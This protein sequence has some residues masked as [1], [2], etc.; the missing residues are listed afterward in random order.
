MTYFL[1]DKPIERVASGRTGGLPSEWDAFAARWQASNIEGGYRN[2]EDVKGRREV[3]TERFDTAI[4]TLGDQRVIEGLAERGLVSP[5]MKTLNR[6]LYRNSP[7]VVQAIEEMARADAADNPD[8]WG[9]FDTSDDAVEKEA[10][11]RTA[12]EY[13]ELQQT[14]AMSPEGAIRDLA[15]E[16]GSGMLNQKSIP[17]LVMGGGSGSFLRVAGTEALINMGVEATLLPSQ[18]QVAEDLQIADPNVLEQLGTA[19]VAGAAFGVGAEALGRGLRYVLGRRETRPAGM[20]PLEA[21]MLTQRLE[22]AISGPRADERIGEVLADAMP[23]RP[24]PP[25]GMPPLV[26]RED[27]QVIQLQ[28]NEPPFGRGITTEVLPPSGE[29]VRGVMDDKS[30]TALAQSAL[31]EA[32]RIERA[33]TGGKRSPLMQAMKR[34]GIKINP[35]TP[36]GQELTQILGGRAEANRTVPGFFSRKPR[37]ENE[38]NYLDNMVASEWE[39][40][41]PGISAA[42]GVENGYL[43]R[44]GVYD[45]I[46]REAAKDFSWM[47]GVQEADAIRRGVRQSPIDEWSEMRP[48]DPVEGPQHLFIDRDG[49]MFDRP[50]W[51]VEREIGERVDAYLDER[52]VRLSDAERAEVRYEMQK[53]GGDI[54]YLLERVAI[55]NEE[56]AEAPDAAPSDRQNGSAQEARGGDAG[57]AGPVTGQARG[58]DGGVGYGG[59][60]DFPLQRTEAG[61][62]YLVPGTERAQTGVAQRQQAELAARQQQSMMRRGDQQRVEDDPE[63][64]FG[65]GQQSLFDD[66]VSPEARAVQDDIAADLRTQIEA[67]GDFMVDMGDGKGERMASTVLDDLDKGDDFADMLDLCGK[68]AGGA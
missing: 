18:F 5:E 30:L 42:A 38:L 9:D 51:E 22:G 50:D 27:Q 47:Q 6:A 3:Q 32:D 54:D 63:S 1:E 62:Q 14:I 46:R 16:L 12:A 28:D 65:G 8:A 26:L 13:E 57:A 33:A 55:R 48:P 56:F 64:L 41:F 37:A 36:E 11:A 19:A 21:E 34:N 15:A 52:G 35:D 24:A 49:M 4:N 25:P 20:A 67:D 23:S 61:D 59:Q 7:A 53:N 60:A 68:P 43:S 39:D 2:F 40:T 29:P 17:F 10:L 45:L 44:D 31:D 66:P 58:G